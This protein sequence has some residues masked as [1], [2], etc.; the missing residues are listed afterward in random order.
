VSVVFRTSLKNTPVGTTCRVNGEYLDNVRL[1][2]ISVKF[3]AFWIVV[4]YSQ[5]GDFVVLYSQVGD[6]VV[7]YSQVGDFVVLY[8]Q[9]GDFVVLCSQ[10]SDYQ[11]YEII[12]YL[13]GPG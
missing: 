13:L 12:C 3:V 10:V 2:W 1:T 8:S 7:L 11:L 9:V 6:F 5:V 4:L